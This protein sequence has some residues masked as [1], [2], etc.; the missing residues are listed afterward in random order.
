M[1]LKALQISDTLVKNPG[2]P[3][4]WEVNP[5]E[6]EVIGLA[7]KD[8]ILLK[9]KVDEFA[10]LNIDEIRGLF[11]INYYDY[12]FYFKLEDSEGVEIKTHGSDPTGNYVVNLQRKVLYE[13]ENGIEEATMEFA[14]WK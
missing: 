5:T 1:Q 8:R 7:H 2:T 11:M 10:I 13:D 4:A 6:V 14:L 9:E 3:T 12:N